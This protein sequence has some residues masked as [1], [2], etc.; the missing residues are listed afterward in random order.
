MPAWVAILEHIF[1]KPSLLQSQDDFSNGCRI[2]EIDKRSGDALTFWR[3][4]ITW[5]TCR[6]GVRDFC[7]AQLDSEPHHRVLTRENAL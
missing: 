6:N 5:R 3:R 1:S 4:A 7:L 2:V